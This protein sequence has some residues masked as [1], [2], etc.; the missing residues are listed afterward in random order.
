MGLELRLTFIPR[1][2]FSAFLNTLLSSY[3]GVVLRKSPGFKMAFFFHFPEIIKLAY[4][5]LEVV[6]PFSPCLL[7]V[8]PKSFGHLIPGTLNHMHVCFLRVAIYF[9]SGPGRRAH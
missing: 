5:R 7:H 1:D 3:W 8:H 9:K 6:S 2:S 4:V